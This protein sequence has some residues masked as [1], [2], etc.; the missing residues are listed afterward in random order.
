MNSDN[1]SPFNSLEIYPNPSYGDITINY[2][3]LETMDNITA[4]IFDVAGR[5]IWENDL[6]SSGGNTSNKVSVKNI[7][8]GT[9]II[10]LRAKKDNTLKY[11]SHKML[12]IK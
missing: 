5:L 12:I 7:K 3:L 2:N 1:F 6:I 10:E 9:Y 11:L 4:K 8:A